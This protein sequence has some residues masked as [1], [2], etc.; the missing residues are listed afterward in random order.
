MHA[1]IE[2]A[3]DILGLQRRV[4]SL[5]VLLVDTLFPRQQNIARGVCVRQDSRLHAG[6]TSL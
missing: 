6:L 5:W 2:R 3:V 4:A 1:E